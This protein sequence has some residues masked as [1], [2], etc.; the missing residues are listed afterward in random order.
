MLICHRLVEV[1]KMDFLFSD[2]V[3]LQEGVLC[4]SSSFFFIFL[5]LMIVRRCSRIIPSPMFVLAAIICA[6]LLYESKS[7]INAV[8]NFR[9]AHERKQ[10]EYEILTSC[11][12]NPLYCRYTWWSVCHCLKVTCAGCLESR[13]TSAELWVD[14]LFFKFVFGGE[15]SI[16]GIKLL[17]LISLVSVLLDLTWSHTTVSLLCKLIFTCCHCSPHLPHIFPTSSNVVLCKL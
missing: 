6:Q 2:L 14:N 16:Y 3:L 5:F 13:Q 9:K 12:D 15:G 4:A 7:S 8:G 1:R 11:Y 17:F 10:W